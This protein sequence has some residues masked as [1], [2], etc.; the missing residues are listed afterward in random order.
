MVEGH[1]DIKISLTVDK[2]GVIAYLYGYVMLTLL[3]PTY[4]QSEKFKYIFLE[5][6]GLVLLSFPGNR[7]F[8]HFNSRGF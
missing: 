5:L 3:K 8:Y 1:K 7:K 4:S 6:C 2:E